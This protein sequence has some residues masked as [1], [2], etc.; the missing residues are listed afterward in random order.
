MRA[1]ASPFPAAASRASFFACLRRELSEGRSGRSLTADIAPPFTNRLHPLRNQAERRCNA[2][3]FR[4]Q[5]VGILPLPRVGGA[6]SGAL[7]A[8]IARAGARVNRRFRVRPRPGRE[9]CHLIRLLTCNPIGS[10]RHRN[11]IKHMLLIPVHH[12]HGGSLGA[13]SARSIRMMS[14]SGIRRVADQMVIAAAA[15]KETARAIDVAKP[16]GLASE[17]TLPRELPT[18]LAPITPRTAPIAITSRFCVNN[19]PLTRAGVAPRAI[20]KP[21]SWVRSATE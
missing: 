5:Q 2:P 16:T 19:I 11:P 6:L 21:I 10:H 17:I 13:Y 7:E 20:R 4:R 8:S 12:P 1:M 18:A 15:P 3:R 9:R 14:S